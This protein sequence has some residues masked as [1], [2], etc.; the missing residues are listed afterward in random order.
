MKKWPEKGCASREHV[1]LRL[2][3]LPLLPTLPGVKGKAALQNL[4]IAP[5]KKFQPAHADFRGVPAL[6]PSTAASQAANGAC[7]SPTS[8]R[9]L[10]GYSE[11]LADGGRCKGHSRLKVTIAPA[12]H[13]NAK[14][15]KRARHGP[16]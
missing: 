5:F 13:A 6:A 11:A 7:P 15:V 12:G 8:P 9:G 4:P 16:C 1:V 2:G 10:H 3:A 14:H